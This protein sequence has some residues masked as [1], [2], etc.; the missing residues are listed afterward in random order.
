LDELLF[1]FESLDNVGMAGSKLLFGDG[2]LQEAGGIV[3]E[4]GDPWNYGRGNNPRDPRF[5]YTR[6]VD[7]VSGAALMIPSALW[8][9]V[10]GFSLELAPAYFEDV[11]LAFKVKKSGRR[12]VLAPFSVV[13]HFEGLSNGTDVTST[14]GMKRFQEI[15]RPK[16]KRKW[17]DLYKNNGPIGVDPD[18]NKDR[19]VSK[20]A[21]FIDA[22]TPRI[23]ND[24]G[25][26]AAIQEMRL[27]QSLGCKVT[28][29]PA[30]LAYIGRH[31]ENLQRMG[32]EVVYAPFVGSVE[33][34][35]KARGSEF[36]LVYVA[37]YQVGAAVIGAV[38][39]YCPRARMALS[40]VDLH[41]LRS[42]RE[43]IMENARAPQLERTLAMRKAELDLLSEVDLALT[44]SPVEEA[45]L[46]SHLLG[47][48]PSGQ[49]PWVLTTTQDRPDF[50]ERRD[51][52]FLGGFGH[53]PNVGA[54]EFFAKQVM[55]L[56]REKAPGIVFNVYGSSLP[57][58]IRDLETND[59][60]MKGFVNDISEVFDTCRIFVAPLL[61]GAGVKG[62]VLDCIA[63]AVPSVISSVAA[64]GVLGHDSSASI[65]AD[66]PE[67]WAEAIAS[68]YKDKKRWRQMSEAAAKL[69]REKYSF[70]AGRQQMRSLLEA[71]D[72]FTPATG[73][74]LYA[75]SS[76][77][78][79]KS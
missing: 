68:L 65:I 1:A 28:F 15:N 59:I 42:L 31:T 33:E 60:V 47:R 53:P 45:V 21:L 14:S 39:E 50:D 77:P 75:T 16:F 30:N 41:F 49:I 48:P 69:A 52:A 23:D 44:Y 46:T 55:P 78:I 34:L 32:V 56:L 27:L 61:Y 38:R 12:V 51:V 18:L 71:I 25:S 70:E 9:E 79:I 66:T 7:Y 26:Y 20:R 43:R 36:D 64:E 58:S 74:A 10:G 24:A 6:E 37:R 35:L 8:A 67:E 63:A 22:D 3:W 5:C 13:Y 40:V 57:D 54:V 4:T 2:S 17:V 72:I 19:G 29:A 62:K 73:G 76:R 11:D